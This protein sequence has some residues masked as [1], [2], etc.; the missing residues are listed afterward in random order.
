MGVR[1]NG[2][3]IFP[4][5]QITPPHS[6]MAVNNVF[7]VL[8]TISTVAAINTASVNASTSTGSAT[9]TDIVLME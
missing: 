4:V 8:R 2:R 3:V 7:T 6:G 5:S 1:N 9:N